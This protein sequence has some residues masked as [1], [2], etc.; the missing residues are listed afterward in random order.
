MTRH[1]IVSAA[2][3]LSA[4]AGSVVL[5]QGS[6]GSPEDEKAI[7]K[8]VAAYNAAF[9]KGD[10][11]AFGA[12]FGQDAEFVAGDGQRIKGRDALIK[13]M[14]DYHALHPGD[15]MR[16]TVDGLRFL[17]AGVAEV[18]GNAEVRGPEG[19]PDVGPYLA[20]LV[21][22]DGKWRFDSVRDLSSEPPEEEMPAAARLRALEWMVGDWRQSSAGTAVQG[23]CRWDK[24]RS[25]LLWDYTIKE[26]GD[27]LMNVTQRIGWDPLTGGFRSW[28]FDSEGGYAEGTWEPEGGGWVIRQSGVLPDGGTG[29][30][31][32]VLAP[33][34]L[35]AFGWRMTNRRVDGERLPDINVRFTRAGGQ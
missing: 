25:F 31:T 24:N 29:S 8:T 26:G 28:I 34:S 33:E 23:S 14:Q 17:A 5:A 1:W 6:K 13:R 30:A 2:V 10:G 16:L 32:A 9:D 20:L 15:R 21:K 4:L 19:P 22:Q 18:E 7:R 35:D 11:A 3:V 12:L 27:D